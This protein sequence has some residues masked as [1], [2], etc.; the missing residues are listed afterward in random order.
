[1]NIKILLEKFRR[2]EATSAELK[3]LYKL[4]K[5]EQNPEILSAIDQEW[6]ATTDDVKATGSGS[7]LEII[8]EKAGISVE[9]KE[10]TRLRITFRHAL[11][12]AAI[13][14]AAFVLSWLIFKPSS[15][16]SMADG[17]IDQV[18]HFR[19][20]VPYGSKSTIELPDS[21]KVILNSGSTF[22]YPDHF[23]VSDRTVYLDGEAYFD[24]SRN[25][26]KPFYVKTSDAVIKVLGTQFNVKSY[27]GEN[28]METTLVSGSVEILPNETAYNKKRQAYKRILLKPNEKAIFVHDDFNIIQK[29]IDQ[30]A[31]SKILT[32]TIASQETD[33]T[34]TDIA[35]KN[36]ILIL[37]NEPFREIVKK[38][39]RWYNVQ[40]AF[41]DAALGSVR[42]SARFSGESIAD[43]L[44]ALSI[45][46]PFIYE[47][48]KNNIK[49]LTVK[50]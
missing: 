26:Q 48:N 15:T 25:K 23:G 36:D 47:I 43:V 1:M 11:Q 2:G 12:Y 38:L 37:S 32:A 33:E 49:I 30:T 35:W 14:I 7:L 50:N 22:E 46:Q 27:P 6:T 4:L 10:I 3:M 41:N 19:I 24:V 31:E 34:Q 9:T 45:T 13:F 5:E 29:G 21:T 40:I 39:E 42:F 8:H 17:T 44:H 20:K 28:I 16:S 18:N